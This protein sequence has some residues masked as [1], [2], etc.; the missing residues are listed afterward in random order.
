MLLCETHRIAGGREEKLPQAHV[1]E[2]QALKQIL[3]LRRGSQLQRQKNLKRKIPLRI[4]RTHDPIWLPYIPR[5]YEFQ[6]KFVFI[7]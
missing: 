2:R 3:F 1:L 5:N 4:A 6:L 7:Y